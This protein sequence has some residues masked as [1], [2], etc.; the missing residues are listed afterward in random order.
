MMFVTLSLAVAAVQAAS[1]VIVGDV[2]VTAISPVLVRVEPKG[3]N[4]YEDRS[5]FMVVERDMSKALEI[6]Q[7]K[8]SEGTLLLTDSYGVLLS[9]GAPSTPTCS[10]PR[11]STDVE[12]SGIVRADK[13]PAGLHATDRDACCKACE[14]DDSCVAWV[15]EPPGGNGANCFPLKDFVGLVGASGREFGCST[16]RAVG[17]SG[18]KPAIP[19]SRNEGLPGNAPPSLPPPL[20]PHALIVCLRSAVHSPRA[21]ARWECPHSR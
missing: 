11:G 12:Q 7:K 4:G 2:R 14:S 21:P 6:T 19:R 20:H 16:G 9:D 5:T 15:H 3:P 13:Y 10:A 1:S 17:T 18:F 8:T